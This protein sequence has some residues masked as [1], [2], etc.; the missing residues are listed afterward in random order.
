MYQNKII[1]S[2]VICLENTYTCSKRAGTGGPDG[3]S[4]FDVPGIGSQTRNSE[5]GIPDEFKKKGCPRLSNEP[6]TLSMVSN[7]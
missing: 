5:G 2:D 4:T 7:C 1:F 3:G 6:F